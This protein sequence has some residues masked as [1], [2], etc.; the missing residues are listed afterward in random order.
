MILAELIFGQ[1]PIAFAKTAGTIGALYALWRKMNS[2]K[3]EIAKE[4][5]Q[6]IIAEDAEA[7]KNGTPQPLIVKMAETFA[8][9]DEHNTLKDEVKVIDEKL[10]EM[11]R[12]ILAAG[13][14][15]EEGI[16]RRISYLVEK[17]GELR[18]EL[19]RIGKRI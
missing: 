18:G 12:R 6:L 15:R 3:S 14:Q 11:E 2:A 10:E 13:G 5:K 19:N 8:S 17:V 7:K 16:H 4:V 9:K 1:D